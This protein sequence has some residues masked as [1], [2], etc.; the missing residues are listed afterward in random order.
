MIIFWVHCGFTPTLV[1][2]RTSQVFKT[3]E[4]YETC[5]VFKAG[6]VFPKGRY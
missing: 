6:V 1:P 5:E 4:V 2:S 3:C